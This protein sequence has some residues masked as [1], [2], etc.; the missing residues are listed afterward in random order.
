[1]K[2]FKLCLLYAAVVLLSSATLSYAAALTVGETY[3]ITL[4][5][6]KSNG[7]LTSTANGDS[8]GLSTTAVADASGKI[9]FSF[10]GVPTSSSYNFLVTTIKDSEGTTVRRSIV[11]APAPGTTVN[12]GVSPMTEA[13]TEAMLSA[14]ATAGSDDPVLVLF[15]GVIIRSGG[16]T[17]GDITHLANI[18]RLAILGPDPIET[19]AGFNYYLT[20]KIGA[21]KMALFKV[22]IVSQ[23]ASYTSKLKDAVDAASDEASKDERAEAAAFLSQILI[24]AA[25][26]ADFD[27]GYINAAMKAASDQVET[28]LGG[29]GALM[30]EAAV[31]AMDSVMISNYMKLSAEKVRKKYTAALTALGASDAMVTR[32][33][34]AVTTLS[35][36]LIDLFKA[37]EAVWEDEDAGLVKATID[38]AY[39][40]INS[41][42]DTAFNTFMTNIAASNAEITV[43]VDAMITGFETAAFV[44]LHE[45]KDPDGNGDYT[46]DNGGNGGMF[47]FHN[48]GGT[49]VNWPIP[50]VVQVTWVAENYGNTFSYTRDDI[51]LPG[52]MWLA[53]RTDF[54][55]EIPPSGMAALMGLREDVE[56]I[57]A[58]K[59]A[60][61][62]AASRDMTLAGYNTLS[63]ADKTTA[64]T[65]QG[66]GTLTII[67]GDD[68]GVGDGTGDDLDGVTVGDF[69]LLGDL[70]PYLTGAESQGVEEL[71]TTRLNA[72]KSDIG[73]GTITDAQ[74]QALIDTS[75]MPDFH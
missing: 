61:L 59:W 53:G 32:L 20:S 33:N 30:N 75:T 15:G 17:S 57:M 3:T 24:D 16:F 26:T 38:T 9:N 35:T 72:R 23:L 67:D 55:T 69:N 63:A 65:Q 7:A 58:R 22:S 29:D 12:F 56:I 71:F 50:M 14:M 44:D 68:D 43:M 46:N 5:V 52:V 42:M 39:T 25:A 70:A 54:V 4:E 49:V 21:V 73:P 47:T 45:L 19:V 66:A 34:D 6:I 18:G 64:D 60:G 27:V 37:F 11:P 51:P 28:Y 13:Q 8:L 31:S 2:H 1:M 74:K 41:D 40:E 36:T 62:S 48:M 10:T